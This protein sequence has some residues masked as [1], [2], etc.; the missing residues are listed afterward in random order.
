MKIVIIEA[1]IALLAL[2]PLPAWAEMRTVTLTI[3]NMVCELCVM[4]VERSLARVDGVTKVEV[5]LEKAEAVVTFDDAKTNVKALTNA[6]G[7][8]GFPSRLRR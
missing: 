3:S 8:E 4:S 1:A 2:V 5:S 6:T 7:Q